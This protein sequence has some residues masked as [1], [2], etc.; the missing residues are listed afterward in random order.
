M[1]GVPR[2]SEGW[3][4]REV[5]E[6]LVESVNRYFRKKESVE[7]QVDT[8]RARGSAVGEYDRGYKCYRYSEEDDADDDRY[9]APCD[10][11]DPYAHEGRSSSRQVVL[12]SS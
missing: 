11:Y 1:T 9:G 6:V 5:M 3:K 8:L 10:P 7:F 12:V 4:I 2:C